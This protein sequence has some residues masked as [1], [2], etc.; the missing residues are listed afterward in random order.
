MLAVG[1][2]LESEDGSGVGS[3]GAAESSGASLASGDSVVV[4]A[5]ESCGLAVGRGVR[6]ATG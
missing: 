3:P 2:G 5:F 4:G 1:S 6:V